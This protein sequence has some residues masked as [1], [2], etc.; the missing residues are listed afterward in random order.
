MLNDFQ[1]VLSSQF[2]IG[3]VEQTQNIND[4]AY[5]YQIQQKSQFL[6]GKVEHSKHYQS[7]LYR[8]S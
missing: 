5:Y 6:I 2:L 3:K 1:Q 4:M 7:E 8:I